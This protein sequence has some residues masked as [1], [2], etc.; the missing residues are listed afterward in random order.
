MHLPC[1]ISST[2]REFSL[3]S[4]ND[5]AETETAVSTFTDFS[6]VTFSGCGILGLDISST[7][8]KQVSGLVNMKGKGWH[9]KVQLK[10]NIW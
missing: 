4:A 7:K 3:H 9:D 6:D 1:D 10:K 5:S 8:V 2:S